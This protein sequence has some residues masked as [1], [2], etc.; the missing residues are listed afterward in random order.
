MT[1]LNTLCTPNL[2]RR[3]R[4]GICHLSASSLSIVLSVFIGLYSMPIAE[5]QNTSPPSI[6][7][8]GFTLSATSVSPGTRIFSFPSVSGS[9]TPTV[10]FYKDG[11]LMDLPSGEI[12]KAAEISDA[13]YWWIVANNSLGAV[14]SN[15]IKLSVY[16]FNNT[17]NESTLEEPKAVET[18]DAFVLNMPPIDTYPELTSSFVK[19]FT[20]SGA[21]LTNEL[22]PDSTYYISNDFNLIVLNT[23]SWYN[24]KPFQV[25]FHNKFGDQTKARSRIFR[26]AVSP[27]SRQKVGPSFVIPLPQ[28]SEVVEGPSGQAQHILECVVNASPLDDAKLSG[29]RYHQALAQ[30]KT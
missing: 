22:Q 5:C 9:P 20:S 4:H 16:Y 21:A 28:T 17:W 7:Y 29:I 24:D 11:Q 25:E 2:S 19:W 27:T 1:K 18:R 10:N 3:H 8:N 12:N 13:G 14:I 6:N 26:L 30:D 15:K 23:Q